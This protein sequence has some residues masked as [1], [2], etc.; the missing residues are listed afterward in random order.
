MFSA[1]IENSTL[2]D[3]AELSKCVSVIVTDDNLVEN[4]ESVIVKI[5]PGS[6]LDNVAIIV[7]QVEILIIDNDGK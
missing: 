6:L 4:A 7:G 3:E 2:S 5:D 1:A